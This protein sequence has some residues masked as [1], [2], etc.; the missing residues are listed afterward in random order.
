MII[1]TD[2]DRLELHEENMNR[3]WG[4]GAFSPPSMLRTVAVL[5]YCMCKTVEVIASELEPVKAMIKLP[6]D[7]FT[8]YLCENYI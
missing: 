4:G 6:K 1:C 7:Y 8:K 2:W 3:G 5:G